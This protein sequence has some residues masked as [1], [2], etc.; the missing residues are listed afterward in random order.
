M[1]L[2]SPTAK[3]YLLAIAVLVVCILSAW[4]NGYSSDKHNAQRCAE[5]SVEATAIECWYDLIRERLQTQGLQQ[6]MKLFSSIYTWQ[7][8]FAESGC[9]AHAHRVGDMA[10]YDQYLKNPNMAAMDFPQETAACGYGFFHGFL[11]HLIQ[12]RPDPEFVDTTCTYL[13]ERYGISVGA[14]RTI[15]YHGSGHGFML[16]A[17]EQL[18]RTAWGDMHAFTKTPL[19]QC[20]A[21]K[22]A[23]PRDHEE[24]EEGVYNVIVEWMETNQYSF[25]YD[26]EK[27]FAS[28][29]AASTYAH[30]RA[31][32]YEMAQKLDGASN[33]NPERM[34]EI[35]SSTKDTYLHEMAFYVGMTSVMQR[36]AGSAA[37]DSI[38]TQCSELTQPT[39]IPF[40]VSAVIAGLFEHGAPQE[41]YRDALIACRS[42]QV[43]EA[44]IS[45]ACWETVARK[46]WRFYEPARIKEICEEFPEEKRAMC[47]SHSAYDPAPANRQ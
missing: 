25:S 29:D 31:C 41:E 12:N 46:L 19:T 33:W 24:C 18:P 30:K 26:Y 34:L 37:Y 6:A 15:C 27:P 28:C 21:L 5:N 11:E 20:A 45:E 16:A 44:L 8:A 35:L 42:P 4:W 13:D 22:K 23:S 7:P 38:L 40:C 14:I 36:Y 2:V 10:Y 39:M 47:L 9:H 3:K 17:V 32:Y 43:Q 1:T